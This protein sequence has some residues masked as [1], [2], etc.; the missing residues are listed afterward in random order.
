VAR[1]DLVVIGAGPGGYVAAIRAAQLGLDVACIEKEA[2]LGG[3]CL[4]IGC[5]PSKALLE[6]SELYH[7]T[8][9]QVAAHGIVAKEV[10]L[11]LAAM[12][13][14]KDETVRGLTQGVAALFKKNKVQ[15]YEGH[16][17]LVGAK[18]GPAQ[19]RVVS[20][21]GETLLEASHVLIATGSASVPLPGVELDGD[22]IG[23]STEALAW[24]EV[25]RHLAVIGA[26]AIGL[27]LGSVWKRLGAKVTVLE[28]LDR[29]LPGMDAELAAEAQKL[30]AKQGLEFRLGSRVSSARVAKGEVRVE[31]QGGEPL[32]CDRVLLAVG[33]RPNTEGLGLDSLGIELDAKGRIPVDESFATS[34]PGVFAIG[35]VIAGPMLAHKAEEE[36]LACVERIATGWGHVNYDAIPNIVYTAPEIAS[37]GKTEEELRSADIPYRKGSFPFL[38]NGRARALGHTEG[39]VKILAHRETD[40]VLGVHILGPRAGDLI[41]EAAVA[42][43]F[44]A[45]SEDLARTPHAHPTLA[46]V[47]REAA[48]AVDGRALH[49]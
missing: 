28:Y 40:R 16:A 12:L 7:E 25:P 6:S 38:A 29:I 39:R 48:L 4:R 47:F 35:D 44:G 19:V 31:T 41:A 9:T 26:G 14:R 21:Q 17:R 2:A 10:G 1:H 18:G 32:R 3:T 36:G 5:I 30:F 23:T 27:E 15:R 46:E 13:A 37:V 24:P 20:K 34:V 11:D 22:R 43:E 33:R 49:I 42:I 8:R 45:S